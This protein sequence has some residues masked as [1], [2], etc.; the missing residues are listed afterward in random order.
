MK[1]CVQVAAFRDCEGRHA[2]G[3]GTDGDGGLDRCALLFEALGPVEEKV[4]R[5]RV[6]AQQR[7]CPE[8]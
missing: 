3:P 1:L 6:G 2:K 4:W 5:K 8:F 7:E